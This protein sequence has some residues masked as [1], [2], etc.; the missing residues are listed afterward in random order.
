LAQEFTSGCP[1]LYI[2][3]NSTLS[4]M[5]QSAMDTAFAAAVKEFED[6]GASAARKLF[7]TVE[8][9]ITA[10]TSE[11]TAREQELNRR[12][13]TLNARERALVQAEDAFHEHE[14]T[15]AQREKVLEGRT[16][17]FTS[18]TAFRI[19]PSPARANVVVPPLNLDTQLL[20]PQEE[21]QVVAVSQAMGPP[22]PVSHIP[23]GPQGEDKCK[24]PVT[25]VRG[26]RH[27]CEGPC[28]TTPV[29]TAGSPAAPRPSVASA[30]SS[31]GPT[32]SPAHTAPRTN[33]SVQSSGAGPVSP[34]AVT[35]RGVGKDEDLTPLKPL[36]MGDCE[37]GSPTTVCGGT[38]TKL[39]EM[40]EQKALT[41]K[42]SASKN[43]ADRS[44]TSSS[45]SI[46]ASHRNW[47]NEVTRKRFGT[48]GS[49]SAPV[50]GPQSA[51]GNAPSALVLAQKLDIEETSCCSD[52]QTP[53]LDTTPIGTASKL[54]QMF[55]EK[56]RL[57]S[58]DDGA[59][60]RGSLADMKGTSRAASAY[61]PSSARGGRR[62]S[63]QLPPP[64]QEH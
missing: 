42:Q 40:F 43:R 28:M 57:V 54:K 58:Q 25:P 53:G 51:V 9:H 60:R 21:K 10:K 17:E 11:L 30:C 35:C 26:L 38:A 1:H 64:M 7:A 12:E 52:E 33:P 50:P 6:L 4:H 22:R 34:R 31:G 8:E 3:V 23:V 47:A 18:P 20:R 59:T 5:P 32:R 63:A 37:L 39:K 24:G 19:P 62:G 15:V 45:S 13:E 41:A 36:D 55:E 44:N 14:R 29:R 49:A 27:A 56:V 61:G 16:S 2:P 46:S 48:M